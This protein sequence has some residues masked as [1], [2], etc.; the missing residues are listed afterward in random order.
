LVWVCGNEASLLGH[1]QGP[2]QGQCPSI[3]ANKRPISIKNIILKG[4]QIIIK[5]RNCFSSNNFERKQEINDI[6]GKVNI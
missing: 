3:Q 4:A 2:E 5:Q 6:S 1:P